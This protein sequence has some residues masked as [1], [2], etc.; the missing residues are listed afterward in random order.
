MIPPL[1]FLSVQ[2]VILLDGSF[3]KPEMKWKQIE[4]KARNGFVD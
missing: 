3:Q 4:R 2:L 1:S